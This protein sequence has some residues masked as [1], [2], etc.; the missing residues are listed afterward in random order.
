MCLVS[1]H[2]IYSNRMNQLKNTCWLYL[3]SVCMLHFWPLLSVLMN[4]HSNIWH[5]RHYSDLSLDI[6]HASVLTGTP[7]NQRGN[8][9]VFLPNMASQ[10]FPFFA[11]VFNLASAILIPGLPLPLNCLWCSGSVVEFPFLDKPYKCLWDLL[12][13]TLVFRTHWISLL[14]SHS[15]KTDSVYFLAFLKK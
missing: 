7:E 5:N 9:D 10:S 15:W 12:S 2:S 3:V 6:K 4:I 14:C 1:E 11:A 8:A 13:E